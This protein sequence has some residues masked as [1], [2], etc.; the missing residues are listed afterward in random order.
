[1][2]I[3]YARVS[4]DD[5]N[6]DAQI[7]ALSDAGAEKIFEEKVTGKSKDR[8]ELRKLLEQLREGDG[9]IIIVTVALICKISVEM[10]ARRMSNAR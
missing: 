1:M 10:L 6:L 3:G 4:T 8:P 7:D 2:I 9:Y 5:Q